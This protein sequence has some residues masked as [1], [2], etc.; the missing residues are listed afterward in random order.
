MKDLRAIDA[1]AFDL[2]GT[3]VDSAPDIAHALNT[4]L[5]EGGW[6][7][8]D[9]GTVRAW[10]GDGPDALIERALAAHGQPQPSAELRA[11]LRT[12]FDIATLSAPLDHG[13]VFDNI[14]PVLKELATLMPLVVVTNKPTA[15]ARAVLA[16]AG[17]LQHLCEVHGADAPEQR[18]PSPLLL[19][20]AA[21]RLGLRPEQ[22]LMVGD[23]PADVR[24]ARAA[25]C[26]PALVDWGYAH[27][28]VD[29]DP[30]TWRVRTPLHL[31]GRVLLDS[32]A[33]ARH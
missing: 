33:A 1:I 31:L 28:A 22:I 17:L 27:A 24:A 29:D 13:S 16:A 7:A 8:F 5:R 18:K 20:A 4:A 32:A 19:Q 3:L 14:E 25:G 11:R 15:L 10:I 12:A 26:T 2:D 23:G 9:L 30:Q 6:P 21:Q